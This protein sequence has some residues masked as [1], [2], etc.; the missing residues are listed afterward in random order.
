M[1]SAVCAIARYERHYLLEWLNYH[2]TLGFD[3][4]YLYDNNNPDDN[5]TTVLVHE[6]NLQDSVIVIDYRGKRTCQMEAYNDC[7]S[8]YGEEVDW[9]A[10]IDLDEFLTFSPDQPIRFIGDY[11]QKVREYNVILV[12]WM[13]FGDNN[14][15]YQD[16][17]KVVDRFLNSLPLDSDINK[18]I[19]SI[20]KTRANLFFSANPHHVQGDVIPCDE[21]Q[22]PAPKNTPFKDASFDVLYIRHYCTKTIE[23]YI[24][25]KMFRGAA[26]QIDSPY[27][28]LDY[29]YKLNERTSEKDAVT[30]RLLH[31]HKHL[32]NDSVSVS[33]I[34]P[35]YNHKKYL[36]QRIDSI[37]NQT[38][39]DFEIILLDDCSRDGS[40]ELL[41]SYQTCPYVSHIIINE[42]NSGSPFAQWEK[43]INLARGEYI[44]IAESDDYAAP[45]FLE[46]TVAELRNNPQAS[47]CY[48]GSYC[49]NGDGCILTNVNP[50]AWLEDGK[51]YTFTDSISYSLSHMFDVNSVYNA[52]MVLFRKKDCLLN[53]NPEYRQMRYSGD[54]LFWINQ[55]SKGE[56][57]E[58]RRKL[59]YFRKHGSNTTEKGADDGNSLSEVVFIKNLFYTQYPLGWKAIMRSK[60]QVYRYVKYIPVSP[61][62]RKQLFK[63]IVRQAHITF[64]SY[65]IGRKILKTN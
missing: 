54:W 6:N 14:L 30:D 57:V 5:S 10:F 45:T 38:F 2:L 25:N 19:K 55:I 44:W 11:L 27:A 36:K 35:N 39:D 52:S 40:Q 41:L 60:A 48:T 64:W 65:L 17:R 22:N 53:V 42:K 62:R 33:V 51:S 28:A 4:I 31:F 26:D 59:N 50:D 61:R 16:D 58:L 3:Y 9:I 49:V 12:N 47:I 21:Y 56:V 15:A 24:K 8:S 63:M 32:R 46:S 37:L 7:Y 34:I 1:K 20:V 43:G 18:H 29:F 23:E 13:C